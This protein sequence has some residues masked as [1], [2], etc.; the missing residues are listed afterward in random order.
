MIGH[1][2]GLKLMISSDIDAQ[3]VIRTNI[4]TT[5]NDLKKVLFATYDLFNEFSFV[6][7][8]TYPR[9]SH[10]LPE[11]RADAYI[12]M[13]SVLISLRTTL[14]N[15]RKAVSAFRKKYATVFDVAKSSPEDLAQ[16]INPAGMA[17][18]KANTII[19]VSKYLITNFN[20]DITQLKSDSV[21][22]TRE[23][24]LKISGI[25]EKS[26][27]CILE[28]GFDMPSIVVDVNVFRVISRIFSF[29]WAQKPDFNSKSQ[30]QTIKEFLQQILPSN[31]EVHQIVHT[32]ILLQ[33]KHVCTSKPKCRSCTIQKYCKY[34]SELLE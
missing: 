30:V 24:L 34:W 22:Q 33:G 31:F 13:V 10:P 26:A 9:P 21:V 16:C 12:T 15:E 19:G 5:N 4:C 11:Y 23:N 20:G 29:S 2:K 7:N 28:L 27:D 32:M 17:Q 14:E 25:G 18:R 1:M 3:N 8:Q 6:D